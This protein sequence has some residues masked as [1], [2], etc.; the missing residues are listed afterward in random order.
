MK[1]YTTHITLSLSVS[2]GIEQQPRTVLVALLSCPHQRRES[3]LQDGAALAYKNVP[4]LYVKRR[5]KKLMRR[6]N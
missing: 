5:E 6:L 3:I 2:P 1:R 4:R